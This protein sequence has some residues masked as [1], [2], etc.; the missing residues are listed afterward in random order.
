MRSSP[1]PSPAGG[2]GAGSCV[3]LVVI[4]FAP[5]PILSSSRVY[6]GSRHSTSVLNGDYRTHY[7]TS[8]WVGSRPPVTPY[9]DLQP[10]QRAYVLRSPGKLGGNGDDG[11]GRARLQLAL[12]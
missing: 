5:A 2:A 7:I 3:A 8:G 10:N 6:P 11:N 4:T 12:S 1:R 9:C